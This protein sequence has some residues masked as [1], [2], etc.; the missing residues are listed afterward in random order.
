MFHS[1]HT[2]YNPQN[3]QMK[4]RSTITDKVVLDWKFSLL[5]I[6][7]NHMLDKNEYRELKRLAKKVN[8]LCKIFHLI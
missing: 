5:D 3:N 1:E 8:L 2:R 7:Q 4:F 6:N